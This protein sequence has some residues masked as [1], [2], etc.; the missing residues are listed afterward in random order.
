MPLR[1][2]QNFREDCRSHLAGLYLKVYDLSNNAKDHQS[3]NL[4][5]QKKLEAAKKL[6]KARLVSLE[7]QLK[8]S[9][10]D[11]ALLDQKDEIKARIKRIISAQSA[12][13]TLSLRL[14][15]KLRKYRIAEQKL[16]QALTPLFSLAVRKY[17]ESGYHISLRYRH[18]CP[19]YNVDC[20]LSTREINLL[21][22]L[23]GAV[24]NIKS[25][26]VLLAASLAG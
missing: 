15:A 7:H 12:N 14:R 13:L 3:L 20:P 18:K 24:P 21:S 19:P 9:P 10:Y 23:N 16:R 1:A 6:A 26:Q 4:T 8:D 22:G 17:Q 2:G 5:K 11:L 25:C